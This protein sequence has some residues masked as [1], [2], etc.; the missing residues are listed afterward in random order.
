MPEV[1]VVTVTY[2][3]APFIRAYLDSL[4]AHVPSATEVVVV[5]NASPDG[6]GDIVARE[7]PQVRL[8][9]RRRNDGFATGANAGMRV[10]QGDVLCLLNPDST[11]TEDF[12]TPALAYLSANP[13][14]GVLGPKILNPDGSLQ[15]SCRRFPGHLS[16]FFNRYSLLTRLL[17][18]NRLSRDYLMSDWGHGEVREVDWVSGACMFLTRPLRDTVGLFDEAYFF[19]IEDVDLCRR[20]RDAGFKVVYFPQ[21]SVVHAIGASKGGVPGRV[22]VE[23]HK[24]MWRYYR[25]HMSAGPVVDAA[26]FAGIV[27]RGLVHLTANQLRIWRTSVR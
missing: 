14:I 16:A 4:L 24:G 8:L 20:A 2:R 21:V 25:K 10:A 17:P 5:D 23:R 22:I 18:G 6:T 12:L 3:A 9:R 19:S 27:V 11:V 7:Y 1:S 26:T 13:A 15:L